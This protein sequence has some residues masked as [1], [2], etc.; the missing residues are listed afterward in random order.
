MTPETAAAYSLL[1]AEA[2]RARAHRLLAIGL[3]D[4]LPHFLIDTDRL[5]SL[6]DLVLAVTREGYPTLDVPFH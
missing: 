3:Q 6:A 1:T 5:T 4:K 2:V